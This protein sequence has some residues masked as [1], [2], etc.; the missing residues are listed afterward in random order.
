MAKRPAGINR[1][2]A[3]GVVGPKLRENGRLG[4]DADRRSVLGGVAGQGV[5]AILVGDQA[6]VAFGAFDVDGG[7]DAVAVLG[8][9]H[10][11]LALGQ[12]GAGLA[13]GRADEHDAV[14][15]LHTDLFSGAEGR[16]GG[17]IQGQDGHG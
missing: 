6:V 5:P 11:L 10:E 17:L 12:V 7:A 1:R 14:G 3:L 15:G 9:G 13:G 8:Q 2:S 4:A 16:N